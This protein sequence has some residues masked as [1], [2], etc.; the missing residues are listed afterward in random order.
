ME[1]KGLKQY[2]LKQHLSP[3][4]PFYAMLKFINTPSQSSTLC[5]ACNHQHRALFVELSAEQKKQK[6][7]HKATV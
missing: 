2:Q 7:K 4:R 3:E 1:I 5:H 6:T